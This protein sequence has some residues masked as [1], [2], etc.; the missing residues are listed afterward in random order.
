MGENP[1]PRIMKIIPP[2]SSHFQAVIRKTRRMNDGIR[3]IK[4]P[5]IC[6]QKV[7]SGAKESRANRLMN[8]IARMHNIRGTQ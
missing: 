1:I 8:S 2:V 7:S 5:P 6:C 4:K 3:W